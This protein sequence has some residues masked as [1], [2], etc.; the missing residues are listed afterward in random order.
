MESLGAR[1]LIFVSTDSN[2][3]SENQPLFKFYSEKWR[4]SRC[5]IVNIKTKDFNLKS[6]ENILEKASKFGSTGGIFD[7]MEFKVKINRYIYQSLMNM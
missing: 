5:V 2:V 6:C 4:N 3:Q 1:T 7:L